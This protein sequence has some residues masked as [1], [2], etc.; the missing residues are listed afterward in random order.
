MDRRFAALTA[1]LSIA[2]FAGV[3]IAT[4]PPQA[5]ATADQLKSVET[6]A[7][8]P[9]ARAKAAPMAATVYYAGCD[10][11]RA[12]GRAPLFSDQPGYRSEMDGDDDGVACEPHA[13]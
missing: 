1:T 12:A 5:S 13:R 6:I 8:S 10:E 3:W 11:V 7:P 2:T 4:T 9:V